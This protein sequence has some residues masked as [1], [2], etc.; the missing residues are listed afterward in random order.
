MINDL[1]GGSGWPRR[2]PAPATVEGLTRLTEIGE[3]ERERHMRSGEL[4]SGHVLT[5]EHAG[6]EIRV[7][8]QD[9]RGLVTESAHTMSLRV[10]KPQV[11]GHGRSGLGPLQHIF[12]TGLAPELL[13]QYRNSALTAKDVTRD[14]SHSISVSSDVTYIFT[15]TTKQ[16]YPVFYFMLPKIT[17]RFKQVRALEVEGKRAHETR[18]PGS[19]AGRATGASRKQHQQGSK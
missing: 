4:V 11:K 14:K 15:F 7:V 13:V 12:A 17:V 6:V 5:S 1:S 3:R 2:E 18:L 19:V 10:R 16:S 8:R 9:M